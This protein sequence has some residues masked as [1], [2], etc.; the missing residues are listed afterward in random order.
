MVRLAQPQWLD[1]LEAEEARRRAEYHVMA[2]GGERFDQARRRARLRADDLAAAL[3]R[4]R[5]ALAFAL[6]E[7]SDDDLQKAIGQAQSGGVGC[8]LPA[9]HGGRCR[10]LLTDGTPSTCYAKHPRCPD[11]FCDRA[12]GHEEDHSGTAHGH[13]T[14]WPLHL[15]PGTVR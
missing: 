5:S 3:G 4:Y 12:S 11:L 14:A 10:Q 1:V 13:R 15:C 9:G 7:L 8:D 2:D 6:N